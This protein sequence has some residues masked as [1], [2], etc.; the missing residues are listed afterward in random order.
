MQITVQDEGRDMWQVYSSLKEYTAAL[1]HCRDSLQ[2][3]CVYAAQV[4]P[5]ALYTVFAIGRNQGF[6]SAMS[7]ILWCVECFHCKEG[8]RLCTC[9]IVLCS[10]FYSIKK[11]EMT[12]HWRTH[13]NGKIIS[14]Y[15]EWSYQNPGSVAHNHAVTMDLGIPESLIGATV[16]S[17]IHHILW[18]CRQRLPLKL[19]ITLEQPLL[20]PRLFHNTFKFLD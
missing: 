12:L 13:E 3:D 6:C 10:S 19:E 17:S 1:E 8:L 20:M 15:I 16:T 2:R 4:F 5:L 18:C 14:V 9:F 11:Q 7:Y